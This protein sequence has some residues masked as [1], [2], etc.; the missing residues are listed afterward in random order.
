[1]GGNAGWFFDPDSEY[2]ASSPV[3]Y[4]NTVILQCDRQKDSFIAAYDLKDG[5]EL[6]HGARGDSTGEHPRSCK[7]RIAP[8]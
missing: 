5:K 3:I 1:V 6:A 8:K 2:A 4:K 7:V